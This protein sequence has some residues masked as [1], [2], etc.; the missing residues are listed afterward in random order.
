[1]ANVCKD[2]CRYEFETVSMTGQLKAKANRKRGPRCSNCDV[3]YL[4]EWGTFCPCCGG[5]LSYRIKG[6]KNNESK[7][8]IQ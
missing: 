1:M 8:R 6:K 7:P 4:D 2:K 5:R 3:R